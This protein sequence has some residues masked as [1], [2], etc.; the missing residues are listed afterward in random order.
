MAEAMPLPHF[1][2]TSVVVASGLVLNFMNY[3]KLLNAGIWRFWEDFIT[4]G[5]L[6]VLPQVMWWTF[7]PFIPN[8]ILPGTVA[9]VIAVVAVVMASV[10]GLNCWEPRWTSQ[11]RLS[12]GRC[13][14]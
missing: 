8:S 9:F 12:R 4:V 7:V 3:F 5:G 11:K 1:V 10:N 13:L 6:S 14:M 2:V